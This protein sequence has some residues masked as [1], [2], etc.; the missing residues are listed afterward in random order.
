M[1]V[2]APY[3]EIKKS[4]DGYNLPLKMQIPVEIID[5][6]IMLPNYFTY[7]YDYSIS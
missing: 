3:L 2:K 4:A 5:N 1:D 6:K 7:P